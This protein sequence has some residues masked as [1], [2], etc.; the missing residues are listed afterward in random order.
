MTHDPMHPAQQPEQ[1]PSGSLWRQDTLGNAMPVAGRDRENA[2]PDAWWRSRIGRTQGAAQWQLQA[3]SVQRR[4]DRI[5]E[6]GGAIHTRR[7]G[8]D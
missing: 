7:E 5:S 3:W 2:L 1:L 4:G 8:A 6:V